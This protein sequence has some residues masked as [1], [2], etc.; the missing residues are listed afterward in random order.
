MTHLSS[1][2]GSGFDIAALD[3]STHSEDGV[4]VP[5]LNPRTGEKTGLVIRVKGAF[6]ARFQEL[7][8]RQKKRA[9]LREKNAVARA[10]AEDE[11]DTPEVMAEVTLGW[12]TITGKDEQGNEVRS[13][14]MNEGGRLIS[15]SRGEAMR[16]YEK[17]P[18]IRGQ[19]LAAALD[20]G[21]FIK[22]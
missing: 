22:D 14:T 6:S 9:A 21:N 13:D 3:V 7:L 11:D 10:V 20:V 16:I 8:A 1:T 19:V 12:Y 18:V 15:F 2:P 17:Y 4:E 5:I